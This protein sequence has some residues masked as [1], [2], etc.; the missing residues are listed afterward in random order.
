MTDTQGLAPAKRL[1]LDYAICG[2][3]ELQHNRSVSHAFVPHFH[4]EIQI[5]VMIAGVLTMH[6]E[7]ETHEVA[8]P[9]ICAV[10]ARGVHSGGSPGWGW[11]SRL[12]YVPVDFAETLRGASPR[13]ETPIIDD[14]ALAEDLIAAHQLAISGE[15][16]MV[17][18]SALV[19]TLGDLFWCH[20]KSEAHVA[21]PLRGDIACAEQYLRDHFAEMIRLE[22]LAARAELSPYHFLRLFARE[23]G[24]TPHAYQNQLRLAHAK[25][26]LAEGAPAARA[27]SEAGFYDQ[28][29]LIRALR[30]SHGLT[31]AMIANARDSSFVQ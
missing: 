9:A 10:N 18:D 1:T 19:S 14:A 25:K 13:F 28:S 24:L 30:R 3:V 4:E 2:G 6:V 7:G 12:F 29:H 5:E 16:P 15:D 20:A 17:A 26:R 22:N 27:A 31:P 23:T 8:P 21:L 11:E